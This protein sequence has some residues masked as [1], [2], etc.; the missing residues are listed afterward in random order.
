MMEK[1]ELVADWIAF[2]EGK[3]NVDE[4]HFYTLFHGGTTANELEKIFSYFDQGNALISKM[5]QLFEPLSTEKF[6]GDYPLESN[7]ISQDELV[8]LVK[9][10][11]SEKKRLC[12]KLGDTE[13]IALIDSAKIQYVDDADVFKDNP[14]DIPHYWIDELIG[15]HFIDQRL[16]WEPKTV[17]IFEAF[18]GLVTDYAL[19]WFLAAPLIKTD[20]NPEFYFRIWKGGGHYLLAEEGVFVRHVH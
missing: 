7:R 1:E 5:Q 14:D 10:D 17:A 16:D 11:L 19:V 18:Y 12:E 4:S 8:G 3:K 20:F 6:L 15:D 9:K 13:F 2:C